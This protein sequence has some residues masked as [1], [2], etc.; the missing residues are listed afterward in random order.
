MG[1]GCALARPALI[2]NDAGTPSQRTFHGT[3]NEPQI[4][5]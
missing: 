5:G 3:S 1:L 4:D 2:E